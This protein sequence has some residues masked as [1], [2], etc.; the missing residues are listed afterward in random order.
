MAFIRLLDEAAAPSQKP[1]FGGIPHIYR[2]Q[3]H[4]NTLM[5]SCI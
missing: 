4:S 2:G 5:H 1:L 3:S